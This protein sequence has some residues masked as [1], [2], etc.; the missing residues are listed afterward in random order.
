MLK[1]C[2][3]D[4]IY[5]YQYSPISE[6]F[7]FMKL[8][9]CKDAKIR[10]NE[11]LAEITEFTVYYCCFINHFRNSKFLCII[12]GRCFILWDM[13]YSQCYEKYIM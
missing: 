8:R 6:D 13:A 4:V 2:N 9:I 11:T 7:I 1:I 10:E 3:M 12:L 5:L